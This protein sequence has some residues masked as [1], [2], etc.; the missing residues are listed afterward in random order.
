MTT[1]T[2]SQVP[3]YYLED[4]RYDPARQLEESDW[5]DN[6]TERLMTAMNRLDDRSRIF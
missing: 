4:N 1:T 6:N 5:E 2:S 3:A